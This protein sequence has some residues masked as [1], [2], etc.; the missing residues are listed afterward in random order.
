MVIILGCDKCKQSK[1]GKKCICTI[2]FNLRKNQL[3]DG[4]PPIIF[5][6]LQTVRM[7]RVRRQLRAAER[8]IDPV[9]QETAGHGGVGLLSELRQKDFLNGQELYLLDSVGP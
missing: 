8:A 7:L 3:E 9:L 1:N 2:A 5:P 6:R 4:I